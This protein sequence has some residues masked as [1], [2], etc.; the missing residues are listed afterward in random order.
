MFEE[1]KYFCTE[2][3]NSYTES[4]MMEF[5]DNDFSEHEGNFSDFLSACMVEN[6]GTL[7]TPKKELTI[8][9]RGEETTYWNIRTDIGRHKIVRRHGPYWKADNG[10]LF[11]AEDDGT[12]FWE[13]DGSFWDV[14]Q[15]I[16]EDVAVIREEV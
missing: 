2:S 10:G 15:R 3:E 4:E 5:Y 8:R 16:S 9:Y 1:K 14:V 12:M 11:S 6:N 13:G 7:I